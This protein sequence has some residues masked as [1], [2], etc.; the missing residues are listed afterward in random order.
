MLTGSENYTVYRILIQTQK[1][2]SGSHTDSL[3]RVVDNLPD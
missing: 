3:G 2:P 1:T